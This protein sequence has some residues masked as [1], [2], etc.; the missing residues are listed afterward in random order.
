MVF[1]KRYIRAFSFCFYDDATFLLLVY[2]WTFWLN[3]VDFHFFMVLGRRKMI[4]Q[5]LIPVLYGVGENRL[6][7]EQGEITIMN[8]FRLYHIWLTALFLLNAA[9][10]GSVLKFLFLFVWA[11]LGLDASWWIIRYFE[12]KAWHDRGDWDN[13]LGFPL[14]CGCYWWWWVCGITCLALALVM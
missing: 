8:H 4:P 3:S 6:M 12:C 1:A 10:A 14:I 2:Y 13:Y 5:M 7:H 11:P 9:S